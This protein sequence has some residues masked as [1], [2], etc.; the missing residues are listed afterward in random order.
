MFA[1]R[2]FHGGTVSVN[3]KRRDAAP[4]WAAVVAVAGMGSRLR[5]TEGRPVGMSLWAGIDGRA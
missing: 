1:L 5:P 2:C 3:G 4:D